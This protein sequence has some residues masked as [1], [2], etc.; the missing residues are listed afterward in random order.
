[1]QPGGPTGWQQLYESPYALENKI[2]ERGYQTQAALDC[3]QL[4]LDQQNCSLE[5]PTGTGKT[6][7]ACLIVDHWL[8]ANPTRTAIVVVPNRTLVNQHRE[9]FHWLAPRW[10]TFSIPDNGGSRSGWIRAVAERAK[11][12][13][14]T[15]LILANA[16]SSRSYP[17]ALSQDIGLA[18]VD[19]FDAFLTLEVSREDAARYH[20]GFD[21]LVSQLASD[22]RYMVTSATLPSKGVGVG[23]AKTVSKF[24]R[25]RLAPTAVNV[26]ENTY[27]P[28][29]PILIFNEVNC[30][31]ARIAR[32]VEALI[33]N[34]G[35]CVRRVDNALGAEIDYDDVIKFADPISKGHMRSIPVR[36]ENGSV[37][38]RIKINND[39]KKEFSTLAIM[40]RKKELLLEEATVG[41]YVEERSR[42]IRTKDG[43]FF[44]QDGSFLF[45]ESNE[46][47]KRLNE[48]LHEHEPGEKT[49][50][51]L[52][53]IGSF[54]Q[55]RGV[56]FSRF[57]TVSR[58]LRA[59]CETHFNR[60]TFE[61][62]GEMN[63]GQRR[64]QLANFRRNK[65][66]VLFITRDTGGRGLDLPHA[67]FSIFFSPKSRSDIAWQE[68]SR[69][70]SRV[71]SPKPT[72]FL[73]FN[74]KFERLRLA[75]TIEEMQ[76]IGRRVQ[77]AT[78]PMQFEGGGELDELLIDSAS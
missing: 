6:L 63:D 65:N 3:C 37:S 67:D 29:V 9:V 5:L 74:V 39:I 55:S 35:F 57:L 68:V 77:C 20:K 52:D 47:A 58:S 21:L 15:P 4:L 54:P 1:M 40:L 23:R 27:A 18:I 36:T 56:V 73:T 41:H 33:N 17:R 2:E 10:P 64:E 19:E 62:N 66:G 28:Q 76:R 60:R 11:I 44:L 30:N 69:I 12:V 72:Y 49:N 38:Y 48:P 26:D 50:A 42:E 16:I 14:S 43:V 51:A 75:K 32:L 78:E 31:S 13:I 46:L 7:I 59:I 25:D 71:S 8:S 61:L 22:C 53:V 24:V 45:W 34:I 70:R